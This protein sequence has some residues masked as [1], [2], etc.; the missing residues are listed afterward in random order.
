MARASVQ[1]A[2]G[3][4]TSSA[5][6]RQR[7]RIAASI[8]VIVAALV[9]G[10]NVTAVAARRPP[11][12][13]TDVYMAG[14]LGFLDDH[15]VQDELASKGF[16]LHQ[17]PNG[18]QDVAGVAKLAQNYDLANVGSSVERSEVESV[19]DKNGRTHD[20]YNIN[21]AP[22]VIVTYKKIV[23]LLVSSPEHIAR[24]VDNNRVTIFDVAKYLDAIDRNVLWDQ[25]GG[26]AQFADP[27]RFLLDTTDPIHSNSGGMFAA[28]AGAALNKGQLIS[29][30]QPGETIDQIPG[31]TASTPNG[32][33]ELLKSFREQG[34]METHTPDLLNRF[35]SGGIDS[36]YTMVLVYENDF[37][38]TML[39]KKVASRD[40]LALMYPDPLVEADNQVIAWTP[41]GRRFEEV[42]RQ[43][44]KL[45]PVEERYGY[46]V[47]DSFVADMARQGI[48]VPDF[49]GDQP[50]LYPIGLPTADDLNILIQAIK[51][52][53]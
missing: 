10:L 35:L 40:D 22:M 48:V 30:L 16:R 3:T 29:G 9:I 50:P 46:R 32:P 5:T 14:D 34:I 37:I 53:P 47:M 21:T 1:G 12:Q 25:L 2:E 6:D 28:M 4:S 18:S 39:N 13:L 24:R 45:L 49:A 11:A 41:V 44:T 36:S 38:N 33:Q 26:N 52:A 19:L 8:F 51:N 20:H 42:L 7:V 43:D 15:A 17:D 27:N 23:D 31:L